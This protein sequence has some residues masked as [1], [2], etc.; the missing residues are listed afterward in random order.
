M[1][2]HLLMVLLLQGYN[3][4]YGTLVYRFITNQP[5][6]SP[7][8]SGTMIS[9]NDQKMFEMFIHLSSPSFM[10]LLVMTSM[11]FRFT[12]RRIYIIQDLLSVTSFLCYLL[13]HGYGQRLVEVFFE[14]HA[15]EF[16]SYDLSLIF[17]GYFG[18]LCVVY[19]KK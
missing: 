9:F 16:V 3:Q 12:A 4:H 5:Y 1:D 10:E 11:S 6:Y 19:L 2:W 13:V 15:F 8:V 14:F 7:V 17:R 18:E